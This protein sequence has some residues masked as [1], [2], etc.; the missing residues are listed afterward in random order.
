[1]IPA[2]AVGYGINSNLLT[3]LEIY[4]ASLLASEFWLFLNNHENI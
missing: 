4:A 1:L 3:M 2:D